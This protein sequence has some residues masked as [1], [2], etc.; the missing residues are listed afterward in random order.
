MSPFFKSQTNLSWKRCPCERIPF[1]ER[2]R[3]RNCRNFFHEDA[4]WRKSSQ[5]LS[6]DPSP[7]SSFRSQRCIGN[8]QWPLSHW[9]CPGVQLKGLH[10]GGSS[11]AS[12]QSSCPSHFHQNGMHFK[13]FSH[14]NEDLWEQLDL[15]LRPLSSRIKLSG[16]WQTFWG[17]PSSSPGI[18]R[19]RASQPPLFKH[20]LVTGSGCLNGWKT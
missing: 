12:P 10:S 2:V 9:Y 16:H 3:E 13:L 4:V 11:L 17:C 7:Q 15:Q 5:F 20:G 8:V 19:Q 1:A 14:K 18:N 6:S